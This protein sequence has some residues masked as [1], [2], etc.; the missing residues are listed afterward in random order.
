MDLKVIWQD[1]GLDKLEEGVRQLF[2]ET[3]I[4]AEK[5]LEQIMSG[6]VFGALSGLL[7]GIVSDFINQ[8]DS[9]KNIFLWLLVLGIVSSLLRHWKIS[10]CSSGYWCLHICFPWEFRV[11]RHRRALSDS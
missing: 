5:L 6:D 10:L 7:S 2:P 8:M 4:S 1:Y 9:M 3:G 11:E